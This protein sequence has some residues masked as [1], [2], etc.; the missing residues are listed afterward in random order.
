MSMKHYNR[1]KGLIA[2]TFTPFNQ[3][4]NLNLEV[5]PMYADYLAK[6]SI[7]GVF[8]CGTS[9]ESL[10]L[11]EQERKE[12]ACAWIKAAQKRFRVIVHVG[13]NSI[14][15]SK[16][17]AQHAEEIGADGIAMMSPTFFK[18]AN[19]NE[20]V[21]YLKTVASCA[22][23]TPFY[24]YNMPTITGVHL[25]IKD[26]L[27]VAGQEIETLVGVKFTSNNFM[28]MA[29]CID[30]DCHRFEILN[31]YD[32]NLLC[33]LAMG[34]EGAVGSTYNYIP[35]IYQ[36]M[37]EYF[38]K[39]KIT[40]AREMQLKS[41]AVINIIIKHGGGVR[42]GKAIMKFIGIN[43]GDCRL[44]LSPFSKSE[45]EEIERELVSLHLIS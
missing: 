11:T 2:A 16:S 29:E 24:Y 1:I 40:Q 7:Q 32:E 18:P 20:L 37:M 5:I 44:P 34:V 14:I 45:Y 31:G 17:L 19:V 27:K 12:L 42:G 4:G 22:P 3:E 30:Y 6:A 15:E 25:P 9:G 35:H 28:E 21:T 23:H 8:I 39:D 13:S 36:K 38:K 10:S 41:I 26:I 33:G 43:C